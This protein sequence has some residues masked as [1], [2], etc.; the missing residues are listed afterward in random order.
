MCRL[1]YKSHQGQ[2]GLRKGSRCAGERGRSASPL[3]KL[4]LMAVRGEVAP[5]F[6]GTSASPPEAS[7][8]GIGQRDHGA[9]SPSFLLRSNTAQI[10]VSY[11]VVETQAS[12]FYDAAEMRTGSHQSSQLFYSMSESDMLDSVSAGTIISTTWT[13]MVRSCHPLICS[14]HLAIISSFPVMPSH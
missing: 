12:S 10:D 7:T 13:P 2:H 8:S 4:F 14:H 1:C 6:S 11:S 9:S 3:K 5:S